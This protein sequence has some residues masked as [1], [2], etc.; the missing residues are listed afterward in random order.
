MTTSSFDVC[1]GSTSR[2]Q[3]SDAVLRAPNN[4]LVGCDHDGPL[5]QLLV[6]DQDV[7]NLVDALD[8]VLGQLKFLELAITTNQRGR[9]VLQLGDDRPKRLRIRW[10][11]DVID[12]VELNT[13]LF[14]NAHGI[15]RRVSMFVV[16]DGD[17]CHVSA[18][19]SSQSAECSVVVGLVGNFGDEFAVHDVTFGIHDDNGAGGEAFERTV[20]HRDTEV[21]EEVWVLEG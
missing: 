8:I 11:L 2:E 12:R 14:C 4:G 21:L 17:V 20:E 13:K 19:L 3:F 10:V 6:L 5:Q 15:D 18:S 9:L 7:Y 1:F 16:E